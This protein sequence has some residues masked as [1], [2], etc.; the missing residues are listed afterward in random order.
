M[1]IVDPPNLAPTQKATQRGLGAYQKQS[2]LACRA[3]RP[4]GLLV[5]SSCSAAIGLGALTRVVALAARD[6]GMTVTVLERMFQGA[7]HP[8]PAAF[9]EGMYLK[10]LIA[11]V[12]A[13]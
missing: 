11:R 3:T 1:V 4:G 9:S 13:K 2:A 12:D 8:V 7:D 5:I 10:S 6:V